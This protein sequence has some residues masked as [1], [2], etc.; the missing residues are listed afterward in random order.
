MKSNIDDYKVYVH[1]FPNNKVYIGITLQKPEYR[2]GKGNKY[3]GNKYI[4]N[5]I[6]KYGWDNIKHEILYEHLT[7]EEAE[8]K[9]IELIAQYKSNQREFGY[10]IENGGNHNGKHSKE[11]LLKMSNA[12][13]GKKSPCGMLNK[14]HSKKTK[15]KMSISRT[16][17]VQSQ[18]TI[19]KRIKQLRKKVNQYDLEGN[20]IKT[21]D[22][23]NVASSTLHI[24]DS[25][26]SR[27]CKGQRN[28]CG[29]YIWKYVN[30]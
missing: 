14:H 10:N 18:E 19:E 15:E 27:V 1:K 29:G 11:T 20:F 30:E 2:W 25:D 5:A 23:I 13:K 28:K 9:E 7:K 3:K 22:S 12:I 26:I 17:K 16:G 8:Q 6:Q 21:W 4:T 24:K